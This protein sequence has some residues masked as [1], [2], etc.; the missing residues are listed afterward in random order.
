MALGFQIKSVK[1][2]QAYTVETLFEAIRDRVFSAGKPEL[3]KHG[4]AYV[5]TFPALD[6][7]NQV[8]ILPG[9]MKRECTKWNVQ[10]QQAAGLENMAVNAA[11]DGL[12]DGL[13]LRAT[14]GRNAKLCEQ[15]VRDVAAELDALG[16]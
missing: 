13:D 9:Q 11:I 14:F 3:T 7:R 10:K 5:I 16:L 4:L 2:K 6:R 15:Q 8:W 12:T 1:T